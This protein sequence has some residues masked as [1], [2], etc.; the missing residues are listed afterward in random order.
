M[1]CYEKF[2]VLDL[3]VSSELMAYIGNALQGVVESENA[4]AVSYLANMRMSG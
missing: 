2:H 1:N 3:M 4:S